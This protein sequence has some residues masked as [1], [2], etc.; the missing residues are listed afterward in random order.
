MGCSQIHTVGTQCLQLA[1]VLNRLLDITFSEMFSDPLCRY[2]GYT[3]GTGF[4]QIVGHEFQWDVL[5]SSL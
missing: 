5:R 2:T 4:N 3:V 1:L